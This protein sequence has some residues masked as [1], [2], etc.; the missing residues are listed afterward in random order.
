MR[1][2]ST[3]GNAAGPLSAS[4]SASLSALRSAPLSTL[5]W[6]ALAGLC[7][8]LFSAGAMSDEAP[9]TQAPDAL[10]KTVS[11]DVLDTIRK[12][13]SLQSGDFDRLQKLVDERVLPH[14]DFDRMTRL[15]V[16]RGW[17]SATE[18]QR[19]ALITEFRTLLL[20]T[21][22]GA[23]SRVTDHKVQMRPFRAQPA[24]TDVIVRT[25]VVPSQGDAIQ[26]DYRLEK[27]DAGWK[28]YDVNVLG[29]WLVENY[30]NEFASEISQNGIDGLIKVLTE[31]NRKLAAGTRQG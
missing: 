11:G 8:L 13:K 28:I 26:L 12:D 17:R 7:A 21:Y 3:H 16:G 24:D 25:Q 9:A 18:E 20:R 10:I 27:T 1:F 30:K 31:K 2:K 15:A 6:T 22:S 5:L 23:L 4:L 14:V 29:V 19:H